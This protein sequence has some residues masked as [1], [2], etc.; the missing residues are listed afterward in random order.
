M[1]SSR[2]SRIRENPLLSS[3]QTLFVCGFILYGALVLFAAII[4]VFEF[5][6]NPP[7][8]HAEMFHLLAQMSSYL[9]LC[10]INIPLCVT[11][12]LQWR[13]WKRIEKLRFAA[14]AG[15]R[16]LL[17][18][19]Q[20]RPNPEALSLPCTIKIRPGTRGILLS[21]GAML[22]I[23]LVFSVASAWLSDSLLFISPDRFHIFLVAFAAMGVVIL[24]LLPVLFL[25]PAAQQKTEV[26]EQG[27]CT[28][29]GSQKGILK[30]EDARLFA[31]YDSLGIQKNSSIVFELSSAKDIARWT[32]ILRPNRLHTNLVPT[33]PFDEYQ[34][35]MQ[36]LNS[37]IVAH[38]GL[39]LIDLREQPGTSLT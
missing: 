27:L 8:S 33:I 31:M 36:A 4:F 12:F 5:L 16:S 30:W 9:F 19:E 7:P 34:A 13:Y 14:A 25:S 29:F 32:W 18:V 6:L 39:P 17:A 26:T 21:I 24:V 15:D 1:I 28:R 11:T 2:A 38:T 23:T 10:A 20:P 35:Q 3:Y 37:L 22:V